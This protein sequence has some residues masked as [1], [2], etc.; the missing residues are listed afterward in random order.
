MLKSKNFFF[1]K[2]SKK[3]LII[4]ASVLPDTASPD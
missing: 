3:L 4:L 2:K 1:E